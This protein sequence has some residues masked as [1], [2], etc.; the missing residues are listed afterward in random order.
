MYTNFEDVFDF[1]EKYKYLAHVK[2]EDTS[3]KEESLQE[4][5]NLANEYFQKIVNYKNLLP[6]FEK[7]RKNLKLEESLEKEIYYSMI[8]DVVNFHD[9]GKIN[10]EFQISK[11][12]NDKVLKMSEEYNIDG[13]NGS[14][15]SFLSANIFIAYFFI[16]LY[17]QASWKF[18]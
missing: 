16:L 10:S 9:F 7:V 8:Y 1:Q 14:D 4:H 11:M 15:H 6:F 5:V 17:Y 12:K 2:E 13:V 3:K 18:R